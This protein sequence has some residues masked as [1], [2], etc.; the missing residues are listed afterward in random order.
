M[1]EG[2]QLVSV[3][4]IGQLGAHF[5]DALFREIPLLGVRRP[6]HHVDV[7]VVLFIVEGGSPAK[8]FRRN[9]HCLG[10]F[11]LMSQQQL[12]PALRG[13]VPQPDG[14]LPLQGVDEGPRRAGMPIDLIH[15]FLQVGE[16]VGGE[17]SVGPGTLRHVRQVAAGLQ[18]L[19]TVPGSNVFGI[20][21]AAVS[22][23]DVTRLLD[24]SLHSSTPFW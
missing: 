14:I 19:H 8:V 15:G 11:C 24:Q 17:Q 7:G 21:T 23:P 18:L 4:L 5:F 10:Q 6:D 20:V 16:T 12:P 1:I 22:R 2:Q 3:D 13:V 9:F